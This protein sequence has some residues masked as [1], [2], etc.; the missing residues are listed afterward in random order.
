MPI[1]SKVCKNAVKVNENVS[2]L[3][4]RVSAEV[5]Q[6][7]ANFI[8]LKD[9]ENNVKVFIDFLKDLQFLIFW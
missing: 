5:V 4:C 7:T 1:Y 9:S 8:F 6:N 2:V 3:F